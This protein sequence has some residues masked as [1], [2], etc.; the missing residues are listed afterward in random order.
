MLWFCDSLAN[1]KIH[2]LLIVYGCIFRN[3]ADETFVVFMHFPVMLFF[4]VPLRMI[5]QAPRPY[6]LNLDIEAPKR[7][8]DYANPSGHVFIATFFC[9]YLFV[10][11]VH[12]FQRTNDGY[13]VNQ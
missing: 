2:I 13:F 1:G 10:E 11:Y 8:M 6:W 12:P 4:Y 5:F 3:D 9:V 7:H